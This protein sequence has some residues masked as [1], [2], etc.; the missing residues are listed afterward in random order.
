VKVERTALM[1]TECQEANIDICPRGWQDPNTS[2]D[3]RRFSPAYP[4]PF[5]PLYPRCCS[6][7]YR[8]RFSPAYRRRISPVYREFV[9]SG[10]P[11]CSSAVCP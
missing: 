5:T 8:R 9:L 3:R 4:R 10:Y 2:Q 7:A 1:S 11:G 6:A